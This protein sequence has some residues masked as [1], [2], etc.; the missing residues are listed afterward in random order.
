MKN[1]WFYF[2]LISIGLAGQGAV[3]LKTSEK[4]RYAIVKP[5]RLYLQGTTNVNT[6]TCDCEDQFSTQEVDVES[7][8]G[9]ARFRS[10]R[11]SMTT[12]KFNCKNAKM[13]RDMHK[14]LKADQFPKI[15]MELVETRQNPDHL[16]GSAWFDVDAKVKI[17]IT[18]VTKEKHIKA[19]AR[20][21]SQNQFAL[22]GSETVQMTEF[23]IDPPEAM[24]G[25]IKVNDPITFHFDLTIQLE[26]I[27][28]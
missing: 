13:D 25:L 9:I 8:G 1:Y 7:N 3:L 19:Q 4:K 26:N 10:T 14:A 2:L 17:T 18:G 21:V 27:L 28:N 20:K 22:K 6:F 16:K 24:F 5:S 23:G 15:S 11:L 12:R